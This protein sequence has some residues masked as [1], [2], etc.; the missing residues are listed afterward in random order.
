MTSCQL[1]EYICMYVWVCGYDMSI[2]IYI[3]TLLIVIVCGDDNL[4]QDV[5]RGS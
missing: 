5:G 1:N 2:V 3:I 4:L